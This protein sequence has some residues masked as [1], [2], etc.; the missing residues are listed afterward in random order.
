MVKYRNAIHYVA[1][2]VTG[3]IL[4]VN[5][6]AGLTLTLIFVAYEG[7]QDWR[8][9]DNSFHDVLEFAIALFIVNPIV[10]LAYLLELFNAR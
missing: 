8:K 2:G 5:P 10:E 3:W 7:L 6:I 4:A 9:H 1:G